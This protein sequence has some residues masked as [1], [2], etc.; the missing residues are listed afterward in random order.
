M[1]SLL[2]A[3]RLGELAIRGREE[4]TMMIK[5][6][7]KKY[8]SMHACD[9][10]LSCSVCLDE[11]KNPKEMTHILDLS[12]MMLLSV[13]VSVSLSRFPCELLIRLE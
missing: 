3:D 4:T 13:S 12:L 9:L 5:K 10:S 7:K 11:K 2:I 8:F 6:K 1:T